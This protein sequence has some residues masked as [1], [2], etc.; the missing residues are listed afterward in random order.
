MLLLLLPFIL[1]CQIPKPLELHLVTPRTPPFLLQMLYYL[2]IV[3]WWL[4]CFLCLMITMRCICLWLR[5]GY[6]IHYVLGDYGCYLRML[7]LLVEGGLQ[8]VGGEVWSLGGRFLS[9]YQISYHCSS[10][11]RRMHWSSPRR[12]RRESTPERRVQVLFLSNI[13]HGSVFLHFEQLRPVLLGWVHH[14]GLI[15]LG[16]CFIIES[17]VRAASFNLSYALFMFINAELLSAYVIFLVWLLL[18][19]RHQTEICHFRGTPTTRILRHESWRL[20]R[21]PIT[22]RYHQPHLLLVPGAEHAGLRPLVPDAPQGWRAL[23]LVPQEVFP[24][25][26]QRCVLG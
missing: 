21:H 11:R 10:S 12:H 19:A 22:F 20:F 15:T 3:L 9:F 23:S 2:P 4:C 1:L 17:V 24:A 6:R 13:G 25:K 26:T 14:W 5:C 7:K 8:T 18:Y 16:W